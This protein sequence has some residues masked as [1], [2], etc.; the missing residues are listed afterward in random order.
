MN[1]RPVDFKI[2][3]IT[4]GETGADTFNLASALV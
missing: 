3:L 4:E 1:E 2:T